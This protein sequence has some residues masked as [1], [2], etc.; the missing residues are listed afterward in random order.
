ME[1]AAEIMKTIK[2]AQAEKLFPARLSPCCAAPIEHS[3]CSAC[4]ETLPAPFYFIAEHEVPNEVLIAKEHDL[5]QKLPIGA[6]ITA[7]VPPL[8][9]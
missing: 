4:F 3:Y 6:C 8:P 2:I 5:R 7:F 9:V 1:K